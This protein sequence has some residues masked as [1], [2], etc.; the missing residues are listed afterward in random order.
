MQTLLPQAER[1]GARLKVRGETIAVSESSIGG[2]LSAAL[3]SVP[4]ASAYYISGAVVYTRIGGDVLLSIPPE[5]RQGL[6]SA[7][8]AYALLMARTIRARLDATWGLAETGASGPSGNRYGD[9]AGHACIAIAG[10]VE[11][12][13]TIETGQADRIGNMRAFAAA[14]LELLEQSLA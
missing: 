6:R 12:A 5:A 9:A 14:A 1:I 10:P 8:E 3:L 13:I 11:K 4:G 7:T 2:L